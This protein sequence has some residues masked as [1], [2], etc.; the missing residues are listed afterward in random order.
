MTQSEEAGVLT[1]TMKRAE[2]Q[3]VS[4]QKVGP[5]QSASEEDV[6][7]CRGRRRASEAGPGPGRWSRRSV[8]VGFTGLALA[9]IAVGTL[10]LVSTPHRRGDGAYTPPAAGPLHP[11]VG[12][13]E[14][15][16][17][18]GQSSGWHVHEGVHS[19]VVLKGTLTVYDE[20][21]R[22]E[23]YGPG[24]TYLGGRTPHLA[25][26]TSPEPAQLVVTYVLDA[27]AGDRP[28]RPTPGPSG[29]VAGS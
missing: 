2:D 29:C 13:A 21:C 25:L 4:G 19:V 5:E 22:R 10:T 23:D 3:G 12:T 11:K 8:A 1:T 9:G 7:R 15:V 28:G 6:G 24:K 17:E 26:N 20:A 27:A 16:Y 18:T 14:L